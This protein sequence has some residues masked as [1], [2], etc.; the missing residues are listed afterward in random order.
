MGKKKVKVKKGHIPKSEKKPRKDPSI[1]NPLNENP[2]WHVSILEENGPWGWRSID[3]VLFFGQIL[4]KIRNLE[5]MFWKDILGRQ[6]HEVPVSQISADAQKRLT[7]LNLDDA[8]MLVSLRLT[9]TQR[10]WGIRVGSV[11]RIL[12]WDPHHQVYPTKLKHT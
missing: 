7:E 5:S 11:L 2:A 8:E 9:G 1:K 4:P 3:E 12:W 10:I 6:N